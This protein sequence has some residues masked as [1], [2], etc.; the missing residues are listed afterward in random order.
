MQ[1]IDMIGILLP[2]IIVGG[3][4]SS[5]RKG[6]VNG[7]FLSRPSIELFNI[8]FLRTLVE[9]VEENKI[10]LPPVW[11]HANGGDIVVGKGLVT[12]PSLC[13]HTSKLLPSW[14]DEGS[15][16]AGLVLTPGFT[17]EYYVSHSKPRMHTVLVSLNK[18]LYRI[19][20]VLSSR[21]DNKII[22]LP[23]ERLALTACES[24]A[25]RTFS[26]HRNAGPRLQ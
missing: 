25:Q 13:Q 20:N 17:N 5:G 14:T 4:E 22:A 12:E 18:P 24:H 3:S 10:S 11:D 9:H 2:D 19:V 1:V 21:S 15:L 7:D 23:G 6:F 26:K 16:E 8:I